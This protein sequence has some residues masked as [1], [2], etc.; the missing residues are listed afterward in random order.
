M[1]AERKWESEGKDS[2]RREGTGELTRTSSSIGV[3]GAPPKEEDESMSS[4]KL[5]IL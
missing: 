1:H 5:D 3:A 2:P 4:R